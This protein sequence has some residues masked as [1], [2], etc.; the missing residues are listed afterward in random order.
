[1]KSRSNRE[2][3]KKAYQLQ[4]CDLWKVVAVTLVIIGQQTFITKRKSKEVTA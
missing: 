3:R 1:M 4:I 2:E